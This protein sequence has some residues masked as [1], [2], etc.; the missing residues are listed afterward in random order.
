MKVCRTIAELRETLASCR[1]SSIGFVPTMGAFHEG[2]LELM[3]IAKRANP[4]VVVSLFVNPTQF[5]PHEDLSKYPR[6]EAQ[7]L[8]EAEAQGVDVV[9]MPSVD[10]MYANANTLV[11]VKGVSDRWEGQQRPEHFGGVATVVSK[12][13]NIVQPDT[14]YFGYKDLQ[15]CAVI[16]RMV[17]DLNIPL[18]LT[19]VET[20]RE[21]DGLAMS[22]RNTYLSEEQRAL[23]PMFNKS[24]REMAQQINAGTANVADATLLTKGKLSQLGL[25]PDYV[26]LVNP[27]TMEELSAAQQDARI[28]AAVR[29]GPVRLLDNIPLLT[30]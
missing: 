14:A 5:A 29:L 27:W 30:S 1:A 23:A 12:L 18:D 7:D 3:R 24:L 25:S 4:I 28:M 16:R 8:A 13:F 20:V 21:H 22:S 15:Q 6:R 10:E 9:F 2:H 19:F 17:S 26:A 11:T